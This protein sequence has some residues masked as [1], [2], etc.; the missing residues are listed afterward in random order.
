MIEIFA[1]RLGPILVTDSVAKFDLLTSVP[2]GNGRVEL[3]PACRITI[4]IAEI[5]NIVGRLHEHLRGHLKGLDVA[6]DVP[7]DGATDRGPVAPAQET[8]QQ[9][10]QSVVVLTVPKIRT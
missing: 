7:A 8:A 10:A 4:P 1:E 9:A 2:L 5:D 3:Q 6:V